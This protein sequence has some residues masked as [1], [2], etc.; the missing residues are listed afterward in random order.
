MK[1]EDLRLK[2]GIGVEGGRRRLPNLQ[3]DVFNLKSRCYARASLAKLHDLFAHEPSP[4]DF[5]I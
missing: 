2:I 1:I 4:F 3:S 5:S